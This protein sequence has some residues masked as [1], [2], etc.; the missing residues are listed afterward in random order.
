MAEV[1]KRFLAPSLSSLVSWLKP[2]FV[3]SLRICSGGVEV[4]AHTAV[5]QLFS[6]ENSLWQKRRGSFETDIIVKCFGR[7]PYSSSV[8]ALCGTDVE[9][10]PTDFCGKENKVP[11]YVQ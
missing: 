8:K 4:R 7:A 6:E 2:V 9:S 5:C 3:D 10:G 1:S 11:F